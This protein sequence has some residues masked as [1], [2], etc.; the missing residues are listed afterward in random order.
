V[1]DALITADVLVDDVN[2]TVARLVD[3]L[4]LPTPRPSWTHDFPGYSYKATFCR[5]HPSLAVAPTLFEVMSA[6]PADGPEPAGVAPADAS[7]AAWFAAQGQRPVYT[8]ATVFGT[9]AF[10]DVVARLRANGVRHRVEPVTPELPFPR[11]FLGTSAEEPAQYDPAVDGGLFL[12]IVPLDVVGPR[13]ASPDVEVTPGT[14]VRIVARTFLVTDLDATV[15]ALR[16]SLGWP[17]HVSVEEHADGRHLRLVPTLA[18]SASLDL[19]EPTGGRLGTFFAR[20]GPGPHAIRI[21]VHGLDAKLAE[22]QSRG[23]DYEVVGTGPT[24]EVDPEALGGIVVEMC[25]IGSSH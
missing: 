18:T 17:D 3:V 16:R 4:G 21:G 24:V 10:Q 5:V 7:I 2:A 13:A 19:V 12:E 14:M 6:A 8:H 11:L 25:E 22:L 9:A 15:G 23:V 20:Y 1:F